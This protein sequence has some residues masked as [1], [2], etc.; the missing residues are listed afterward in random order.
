M[1]KKSYINE[2]ITDSARD[3]EKLKPDLGSLQIPDIKD[4]PRAGLKQEEGDLASHDTTISSSD[5]EGENVLDE[6][7]VLSESDISPLEKKLLGESFDASYDKDLPVDSISLDEK[8]NEGEPLEEAAQSEDFFGK[9]LDDDLETE[10]DEESEG[11]SQ[12]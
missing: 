9:D 7:V 6:D 8:D 10:E 12:Q 5:E 11:E 1:A 4:I 2:D 3:Q